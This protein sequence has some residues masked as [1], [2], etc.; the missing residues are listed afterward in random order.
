MDDLLPTKEKF[1]TYKNNNG[2]SRPFLEYKLPQLIA[3]FNKAC[4]DKD[5]DVAHDIYH[6]LTFRKTKKACRFKTTTVEPMLDRL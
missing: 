3:E 5:T 1:M 2:C 4:F 6:E